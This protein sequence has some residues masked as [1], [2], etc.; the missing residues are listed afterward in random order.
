MIDMLKGENYMGD[1]LFEGTSGTI[2]MVK[3]RMMPLALQDVMDAM[4]QSGINGLWTAAPAMTGIGTLTYVDEYVKTK[5]R[6]AKTMGFEIWDEIDPK[7]QKEI[8]NRS[9]EL[10]AAQIQFDRRVMDTAFGEWRNAGQSIEDVF[11]NNVDLATEQFKVTG[12]GYKYRTRIADAFTARR[13]GYDA[14]E[15]EERFSEI[16]GRFNI[17]DTAEALVALSPEQMAI[18]TYNDA[19]YGDDMYD[20]FGEYRF[21]VA[22]ERKEQLRQALGDELYNY[23][24][25]YQGVRYETFP[26]EFQEYQ[27]AKEV[28]APYWA[29]TDK[30]IKMFGR[31]YA[32]SPRGQSMIGKLRKQMRLGNSE[33]ERLYQLF[34]VQR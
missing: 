29:V 12:D 7:T 20:E 19:L 2:K 6:I 34:Y 17:Q 9:A 14:R 16:V 28:L 32:E 10:Q 1:P 23:V 31:V 4:E 3:D 8:W 33:M 11:R 25:D 24:E 18:R 13:G 22:K 5:D 27:K 30:V 15:K 26:L 21:D